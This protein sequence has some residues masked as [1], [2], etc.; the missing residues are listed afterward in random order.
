M[1]A[2]RT[3]AIMIDWKMN[4]KENKESNLR[5]RLCFKDERV[6]YFF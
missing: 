6:F 3:N 1:T 5:T 4:W 2:G